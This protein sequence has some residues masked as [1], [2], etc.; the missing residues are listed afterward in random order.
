VPVARGTLQLLDLA[1]G[2]SSFELRLRSNVWNAPAFTLLN[3]WFIAAPN[4]GTDCFG[5]L[6]LR[7]TIAPFEPPPGLDPTFQ[8]V[9]AVD[10]QRWLVLRNF[11]LGVIDPAIPNSFRFLAEDPSRFDVS[12]G[13]I[14][15]YI[16][17][18]LLAQDV[19]SLP[20][21]GGM[22]QTMLHDQ[23]WL[24]FGVQGRWIRVCEVFQTTDDRNCRVVD[25]QGEV[26]PVDFRVTITADHHDDAVLLVD[27]AVV[28]VGPLPDGNRAVQRVQFATGRHEILHPGNGALQPLGNGAAALLLQDGAAWLIDAEHDELVA[29]H[30]SHVVS[31][32]RLTTPGRGPARQDDV[33]AL[34]L[35]P[36]R[37]PDHARGSRRAHP[38]H[39]HVDRPLVLHTA[40]PRRIRLR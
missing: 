4:Q 31:T 11:D 33:A 38:A 21:T 27:G 22:Q 37:C 29:E 40:P 13:W 28:Y 10:T 25:A 3:D 18:A 39:R 34:V 20:P 9:E 26:A 19:L 30:V 16:G 14:H 17:Y 15:V 1:S 23:D 7:S 8:F 36:R 32:P 6:G 2:A 12:Q 24:P 5:A 35:S